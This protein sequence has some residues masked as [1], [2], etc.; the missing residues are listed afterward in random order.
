[1]DSFPPR[2][3]VLLAREA[4]QST[5]IGD[6]S[7]TEVVSGELKEGDAVIVESIGG[8]KKSDTPV[9]PGMFK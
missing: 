4:L 5:G 3:H 8:T 9:S 2:L 7:Y 6:G 1:M